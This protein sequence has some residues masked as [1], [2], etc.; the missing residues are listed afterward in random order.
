[1]NVMTRCL[2]KQMFFFYEIHRQK[3]R[4]KKKKLK[5]KKICRDKL[6]PLRFLCM[7]RLIDFGLTVN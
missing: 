6:G 3:R 7:E 2:L 5:I 4:S 1:M